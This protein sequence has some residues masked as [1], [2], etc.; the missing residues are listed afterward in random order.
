M[1]LFVPGR[2]HPLAQRVL[3]VDAPEHVQLQRTIARDGNS[4]AQVQAI[5]AAQATRQQRI[6]GADDIIIN[7]GNIAELETQV[8]ALDRRYRSLAAAT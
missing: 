2:R 6:D 5:M 7:S 1:P 8:I 3:L 4:A